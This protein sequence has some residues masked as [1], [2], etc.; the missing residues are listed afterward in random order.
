MSAA[1]MAVVIAVGVNS[2]LPRPSAGLR[3]LLLTSGHAPLSLA[4][5]LQLSRV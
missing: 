4:A 5:A 3:C 2:S 1:F